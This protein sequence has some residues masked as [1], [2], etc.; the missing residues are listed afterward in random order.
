MTYVREHNFTI[1]EIVEIDK[2]HSGATIF[3]SSPKEK[4]WL[5]TI[6]K[7]GERGIFCTVKN[8]KGYE[9]DTLI[10]RLSK[11]NKNDN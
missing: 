9:W 4:P 3:N 2:D 1:E 8:D 10:S 7:L 11:W 6:V 5:V